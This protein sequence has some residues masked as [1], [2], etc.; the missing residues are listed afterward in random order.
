MTIVK[1]IPA[2]PGRTFEDGYRD[3][4]QSLRPGDAPIVA[5]SLKPPIGV[6]AYQWGF[7]L[8]EDDARATRS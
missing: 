6:T 8:G 3:G 5:T 4:Y 1:N 2:N 7:T